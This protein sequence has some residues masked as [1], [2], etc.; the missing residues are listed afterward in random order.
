MA[1]YLTVSVVVYVASDQIFFN[2][3]CGGECSEWP[4][5]STVYVVVYV[6]CD[7][8]VLSVFVGGMQPM[9]RY[10][11]SVCGGVCGK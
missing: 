11:N 9:A 2:S 3:E 7:Q 6:A 1:R 4:D 10:F 8:L 5:I